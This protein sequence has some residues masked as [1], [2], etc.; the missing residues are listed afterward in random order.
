MIIGDNRDFLRMSVEAE[1][2]LVLQGDSAHRQ[3][4]VSDL[5]AAGMLLLTD[6]VLAEADQVQVRITP[7][8]PITPPLEAELEVVRC[9]Q[10]DSGQYQIACKILRIL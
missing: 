5:S 7:G 9:N 8:H 10:A 6:F 4:R 3:C 2:Q 1:A